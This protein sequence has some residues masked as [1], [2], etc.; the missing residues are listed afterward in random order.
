ME[1]PPCAAGSIDR[2]K[3]DPGTR[4][5]EPQLTRSIELVKNLLG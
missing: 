3:S 4:N 5:S 2:V 1:E